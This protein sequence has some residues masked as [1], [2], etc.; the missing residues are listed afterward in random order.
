MPSPENLVSEKAAWRALLAPDVLP[1]A[2]VLCLTVMIPAADSM[3]TTTMAPAIVD[4]LGGRVWLPWLV[5]LYQLGAIIA[6]ALSGLLA[7]RYGLRRPMMLAALGFAA[8]CLASA[9]AVNMEMMLVGRMLQGTCGGTL[10]AFSYIATARLF[11]PPLI[12]RI[13]G[14]TSGLWGAA[15]LSGPLVGGLMVEHLSWREGFGVFAVLALGLVFAVTVLA[16]RHVSEEEPVRINIPMLMFRLMILSAG[17]FALL[18]AGT[19]ENVLAGMV[20]FGGGGALLVFF[21]MLDGRSDN[22]Y[23]LP[24]RSFRHRPELGAGVLMVLFMSM[25]MIGLHTHGAWFMA[26]LHD[27]PLLQAGYVIACGSVGWSSAAM[28]TAGLPSRLSK[29]AILCGMLLTATVV[30]FLP[31]V[32]LNGPVFLIGL[33]AFGQGAGFGTAWSF[34]L[35][36][37][38]LLAL[39][40]EIEHAAGAIVS[41]QRLGYAAGAAVTGLAA[42]FSGFN[43]AGDSFSI[44]Q[45]VFTIYG[46]LVPLALLGLA[47][48]GGF[49]RPRQN[50]FS[51]EKNDQLE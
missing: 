17:I 19:L 49:L 39:D 30:L 42:Q 45:A 9:L 51:T 28:L 33:A 3:M 46:T 10:V 41:V 7:A 40:E 12:P 8:G 2:A 14:L 32:I 4:D 6:S 26:K 27:V 21:L 34:I 25:S 50:G 36:R 5:A 38:R 13:I 23:L 47:C 15:A 43:G 35:A 1:K 16:G 24:H 29:M 11:A 18:S 44:N 31:S 37:I 48:A 22:G 20:L